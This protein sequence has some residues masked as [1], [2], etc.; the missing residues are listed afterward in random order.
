[1][2][3]LGRK[4]FGEQAKEK[5]IPDSQ[6]SYLDQASETVTGTTDRVASTLQP[7]DNKSATQQIGDTFQG[8]TSDDVTAQGKTILEQGKGYLATGAQ[9]VA[10]GAQSVSDS[11]KK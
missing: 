4:D 6:K 8:T 1:M 9:Y 2:S 3:D 11:L 10:N 7:N 5:A